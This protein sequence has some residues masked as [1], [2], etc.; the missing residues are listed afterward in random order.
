MT[1]FEK[2]YA[3]IEEYVWVPMALALIADF[4][5]LILCLVL[6]TEMWWLVNL[7]IFLSIVAV[8]SIIVWVVF[9]IAYKIM[10]SRYD[11]YKEPDNWFDEG[12]DYDLDA[13]E[14]A[15]PD[16]DDADE[17]DGEDEDKEEYDD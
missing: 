4:T 14:W 13:D 5:T 3:N 17:D 2:V 10:E 12:N 9:S 7:S 6:F 15:Y 8:I 1:R 16:D 11:A